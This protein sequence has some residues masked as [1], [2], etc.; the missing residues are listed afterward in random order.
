MKRWYNIL[1]KTLSLGLYDVTVD[2]Q[3]KVLA[4]QHAHMVPSYYNH[5]C[6]QFG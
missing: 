3:E 6:L 1:G 5:P 4:Q 2:F